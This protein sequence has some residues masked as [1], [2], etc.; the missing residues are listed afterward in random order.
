[1]VS[2]WT[3]R[4]RWTGGGS[5]LDADS[6]RKGGQISTPIDTGRILF[7]GGFFLEGTNFKLVQA[8][9]DNHRTGKKAAAEIAYV[10]PSVLADALAIDEQ[11]LRQQIARLKK[12]VN[13]TLPAALGIVL[14]FIE[15]RQREGYRL[16]PELR[17]VAKG[18]LEA[19]QGAMSHV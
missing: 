8:L 2:T 12:A 19:Y 5:K 7:K 10:A 11:S 18:D 1:M 17:E 13:E 6:G 16:N 15:N 3:S 4:S 9:L 14:E